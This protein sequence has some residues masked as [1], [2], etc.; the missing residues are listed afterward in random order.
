LLTVESDAIV[1]LRRP[2]ATESREL[3]TLLATVTNMLFVLGV[4]AAVAFGMTRGFHCRGAVGAAAEMASTFQPRKDRL[5]PSVGIA[6][7]S[8]SKIALFVAPI[9]VLFSCVIGPVPTDR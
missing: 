8:A 4:S 5:D 9:M 3:R 6:L 1:P 7:G 2:H